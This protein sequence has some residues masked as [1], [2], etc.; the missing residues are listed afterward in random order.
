M[1]ALWQVTSPLAQLAT[2]G[3]AVQLL[4]PSPKYPLW[5]MPQLSLLALWQVSCEA[6]LAIAGHCAQVVSLV[7]LQATLG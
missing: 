4:L 5:H 7:A 3:Q 1:L 2:G 6:Q